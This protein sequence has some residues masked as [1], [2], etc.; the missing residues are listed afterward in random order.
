M[1]A[2]SVTSK[3]M[4][5]DSSGSRICRSSSSRWQ[6]GNG[7]KPYDFPQ[8]VDPLLDWLLFLLLG[9]SEWGKRWMAFPFPGGLR[10]M[11]MR[12]PL[13]NSSWCAEDTVDD[14]LPTVAGM[15]EDEVPLHAG[16]RK[17]AGMLVGQNV[18][19]RTSLG[20]GRLKDR[21]KR[22]LGCG[23]NSGWWA[24]CCW[25]FCWTGMDEN[26]GLK[27]DVRQLAEEDEDWVVF[28]SAGGLKAGWRRGWGWRTEDGSRSF[29]G[30]GWRRTG[31][32]W[33]SPRWRMAS[34]P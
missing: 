3:W 12:Q 16:W 5:R 4:Q 6:K 18:G 26:A 22:W 28:S 20:S 15:K 31:C 1:L 9:W 19:W 21:S 8:L 14:G 7:L 34:L 2:E 13:W 10:K 30:W 11:N 29:N 17:S 27:M 32:W 23:W 24:A 25:G 33:C